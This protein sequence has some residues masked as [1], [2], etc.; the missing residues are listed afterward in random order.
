[1]WLR[2][3][4]ARR[5]W[6]ADFA[7]A[8]TET[9]WLAVEI[10]PALQRAKVPAEREG[11]WAVARPRV[12]ALE[13]DFAALSA[14][15]RDQ[16]SAERVAALL[17]AVRGTRATADQQSGVGGPGQEAVFADLFDARRHLDDALALVNPDVS[18][19]GGRPANG[20]S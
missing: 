8:L 6:D 18:G 3:R 20:H 7:T 4:A 12:T 15:A 10:V 17:E 11:A 13:A 1:M 19:S 5:R 14:S 2:S 9:R 16:Q